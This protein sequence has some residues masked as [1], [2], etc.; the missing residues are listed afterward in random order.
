MVPARGPQT[1]VYRYLL[2]K[3]RG[4]MDGK[5]PRS[6]AVVLFTSF[7]T[8]AP[9]GGACYDPPWATW[10]YLGLPG[11]IVAM[12]CYARVAMQSWLRNHCYAIFAMQPLLCNLC[13]TGFAMQSLRCSAT[14]PLLCNL[15]YA[16]VAMQ[17]L[18]CK[19]CSAIVALQLLLRTLCYAIFATQS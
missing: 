16:I 6:T 19:G 10:S 9:F 18:L 17:S 13:W 8:G 1:V 14:Q 2:R 3:Y 7:V 5:G 15:R 12:L 11:A 4:T